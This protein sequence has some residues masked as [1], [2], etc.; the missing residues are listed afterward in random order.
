M[1]TPDQIEAIVGILNSR[2]SFFVAS[3][4]GQEF[5]SEKEKVELSSLGFEPEKLYGVDKDSLFLQYQLGMMSEVLGKFKTNKI[6]YSDL[7]DIV[8][9]G[10]YIPLSKREKYS[11]NSVKKQAFKDIVAFKGR[12]FNDLN[13]IVDS[14][15]KNNRKAYEAE[16]R[17]EIKS[18]LAKRASYREIS[19][20]LGHKTGDW[21]RN[22]DRIVQYTGHLAFDEGRAAMFERSGGEDQLVHKDVYLG[23]CKH[24]IRLYLTSGVGSEPKVFKLSELKE[25]GTNIGRKVADLKPVIGPAHPHCRCT[26]QKLEPDSK[27]DNEKQRFIIPKG[28]ERKSKVNRPK[29]KVK[30]GEEEYLV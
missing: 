28:V 12:I 26:L 17:K 9:R 20:E 8:R 3:N 7:K 13:N 19:Q 29:V 24:C 15:E 16:I 10:Q 22:W 23:A 30:I 27:W 1:F 6:S 5:L 11:L 4:L 18:G 25:N 2:T 21:L 14:A